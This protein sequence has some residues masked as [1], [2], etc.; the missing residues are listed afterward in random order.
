VYSFAVYAR[1]AAGN[2]STRSGTVSVTTSVGGGGSGGCTAVY[3]DRQP[4]AGGFQ[5]T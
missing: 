5:A 2:R 4:V 3:R 1:D